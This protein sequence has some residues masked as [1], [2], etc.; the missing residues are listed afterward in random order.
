MK[1]KKKRKQ[2]EET[3][4]KP[5][6]TVNIK[7][8][9]VQWHGGTGYFDCTRNC[10]QRKGYNSAAERE[11][12]MNREFDRQNNAPKPETKKHNIIHLEEQYGEM[13]RKL[14]RYKG[15]TAEQ[16]A[17]QFGLRISDV[18]AMLR[19]VSPDSKVIEEG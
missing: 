15:L 8:G 3:E 9:A 1:T 5:M 13:L 6:L 18:K 19:G 12:D 16:L 10:E 7:T 17:E 2:S 4:F 14:R 11:K